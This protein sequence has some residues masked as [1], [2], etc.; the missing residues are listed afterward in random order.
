[1]AAPLKKTPA[2]KHGSGDDRGDYKLPEL[3]SFVRGLMH[4]ED[5]ALRKIR[6]STVADGLPPISIGPDEGKLLHFLVRTC[7]ARSA[8]EIGTLA[9]YSGSWI[10]RALPEDGILHTFEYEPKHARVARRNFKAAG[11]AAKV[12]VIVGRAQE[13]L[14]SIEAEGPFDFVFIDADKAGYESYVRWAVENTESGALIVCDNAYLF[15]KL[16]LDG[17]KAGEDA[18]GAKAMRAALGLLADPELF[19]SCAMIPTG[20]GL[21][22]ALRR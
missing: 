8:V 13:T 20:E 18:A 1:M 12:S 5:A 3:L 16:H 7:G 17:A 21:A 2:R 11:V 19:S 15:G 9:G 6:E 10:A 4:E 22:A 14:P